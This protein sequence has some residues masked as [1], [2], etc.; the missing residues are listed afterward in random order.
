MTLRAIPAAALALCLALPAPSRATGAA[1]ADRPGHGHGHGKVLRLDIVAPAEGA[2]VRGIVEVQ[3]R[4]SSRRIHRV[5]LL[6]DGARLATLAPPF[7][8][9]WDTGA[10]AA[11]PHVLLARAR[12]GKRQVEGAPRTVVVEGAPPPAVRW[13][14]LGGGP[15]RTPAAPDGGLV[16][17]V[18]V[19]AGGAILIS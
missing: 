16:P 15:V 13:E 8:Y 12:K 7:T 18:A 5:E 19:D 1:C 3:V 14:A 9:A 17:T 2:V 11:G 10:L 6:L 4:A